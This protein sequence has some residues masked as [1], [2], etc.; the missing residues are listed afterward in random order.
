MDFALALYRQL[1]QQPGNLCFSPFS[2]R[3]ALAMAE[4]GARGETATQIRDA[5]GG[6]RPE[7]LVG[8]LKRLSARSPALELDLANALWSQTG[9]PLEPKFRDVVAEQ[10]DG[11]LSSL[12]FRGNAEGAR[13]TINGWVEARTHEKIR[14]L[15]PPGSLND[16]SRLVLVNAI[17]F[18][19]RWMQE[20]DA[21]STRDAPFHREDG[22]TVQVPT[23]SD[24]QQHLLYFRA[25]G[26]QAVDVEY[27][28]GKLSMLVVLPDREHGLRRLES[29]LSAALLQDVV[30]QMQDRS[31][32]IFLP[33]F[34]MRSRLDNLIGALAALGITR[35]FSREAADF[36]GINGLRPPNE[37]ALFISRVIHEAFVDVNETGTEAVAATALPFLRV[38]SSL[39]PR[40]IV[41]FRA[42]HPFLFAIRE[43]TTGEI[44]FL[45][46]VTDP[47]R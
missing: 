5:L 44:L 18:K 39:Q 38:G 35:A 36:S 1:G 23:M 29:E 31:V 46:R 42:D 14:D 26:F 15:L 9:A 13:E 32:R 8:R 19:D 41:E 28:D 7:A 45:G 11:E 16:D 22:V 27:R 20:F 12:D 25:D 17:Y 30:E 2:I 34:E 37:E 40:P 43:R 10:Y 24:L 21:E 47:T 3:I 4:A 33:R 6:E